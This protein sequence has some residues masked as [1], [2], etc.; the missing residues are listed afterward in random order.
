[1]HYNTGNGKLPIQGVEPFVKAMGGNARKIEG[2]EIELNSGE[3]SKCS[4]LIVFSNS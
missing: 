4:G 3:L 2:R 1:M